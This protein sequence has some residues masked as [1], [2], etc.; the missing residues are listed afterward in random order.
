MDELYLASEARLIGTLQAVTETV[1]SV[2]LIGHNPGM[3]ELAVALTD[4]RVSADSL[5]R[6][7]SEGFPTCA[8]AEFSVTGPWSRL[9]AGGL[10]LMRFLTPR[11]LEAAEQ[12]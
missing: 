1:R 10:R 7:V 2:L 6:R 12:G 3:H 9:T 11:M 8:L 4:P 5:V